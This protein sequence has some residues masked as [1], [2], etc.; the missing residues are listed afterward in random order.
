M[1]WDLRLGDWRETLADV[2]HVDAVIVDAPYS[3]KT[4][5]GHDRAVSGSGNATKRRAINYSG[6]TADDVRAFVDSWAPRCRGWFVTITDTQLAPVWAD[7]LEDAGRYVF[8][9]LPWVAKGSR[10]RLTGDGPSCWTCWIVVARPRTGEDRRGRLF[11]KWGTL[12]GAYVINAERA[13]HIGGKPLALMEALIRDYT[14]PGD[15]VCDPCA[16][17]G[18]TLAAAIR[19][20]REAIGSELDPVTH[21]QAMQSIAKRGRA[22]DLFSSPAAAEYLSDLFKG[23]R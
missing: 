7:A 10:V 2:E 20:G 13:S 18:T 16:G 11:S 4:H 22:L 6:W 5:D 23:D 21:E 8:A 17:Y 9:P 12:P 14:R 15:L 19:N 1:R 3:A